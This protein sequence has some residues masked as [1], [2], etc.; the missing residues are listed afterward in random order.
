M[1]TPNKTET[2]RQFMSRCI[3]EL[4]DEGNDTD[5]AAAICYSIYERDKEKIRQKNR[6]D[7][8]CMRMKFNKILTNDISNNN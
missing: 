6:Q 5:K 8:T 1:P 7:G 2:R 3:P 4:I